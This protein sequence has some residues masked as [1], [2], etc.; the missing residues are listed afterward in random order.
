MNPDPDGIPDAYEVAEAVE[1]TA[2]ALAKQPF[3]NRSLSLLGMLVVAMVGAPLLIVLTLVW[4]LLAGP[5]IDH[6]LPAEGD[7]GAL[8]L[9]LW[10]GPPLIALFLILRWGL[11]HLPPKVRRYFT[12]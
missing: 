11:V 10:F 8:T 1:E 4:G 9:I 3:V 7:A 12:S 2:R 6:L 5:V